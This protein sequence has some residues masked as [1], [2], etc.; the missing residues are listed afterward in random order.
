MNFNV[1]KLTVSWCGLFQQEWEP[2]VYQAQ[3]GKLKAELRQ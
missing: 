1:T 2:A 3:P